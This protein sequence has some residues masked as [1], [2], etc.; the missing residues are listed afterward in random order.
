MYEFM[1]VGALH[2]DYLQSDCRGHYYHKATELQNS[3]M[4]GFHAIEM[5]VDASECVIVLCFSSMLAL[6]VLA[7]PIPMLGLTSSGFIDYS[8]QCVKLM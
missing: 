7:D 5:K 8:T 1:V 3:A 6:Q 4:V 2:L